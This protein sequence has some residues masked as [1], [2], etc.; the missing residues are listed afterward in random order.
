MDLNYHHLMYFWSVARTG[1]VGRAAEELM[2]SQPTVSAQV[3]A[4]EESLGEPLFARSGRRLVLT[5]AGRTVFDYANE[6][7]ALGR[8]IR[9]ALRHKESGRPARLAV[10][11]SDALP[12]LVARMLIEPALGLGQPVHVVCRDDKAERLL[13]DLAT[14]RLDVVLSDAPAPPTFKARTFSHLLGE[15]GVSFFAAPSLAKRIGRRFPQSLHDAPVILPTDNTMLRRAMDQW[16]AARGVRPRVV[17]EIEDSALLKTFG[18]SGVGAFPAPSVV[19]DVVRAQYGVSV[20][21]RAEDLRERFFAISV[22]RKLR[23]PA[24]IAMTESARR[25]LFDNE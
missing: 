8:Q 14:F 7:F 4:L 12:K 13:V 15:C 10:G 11:V 23:H 18:Q 22:E 24:V 5:D 19:E 6:I 1:G 16:L 25:H 3:K 2:V 20:V 21:G 9:D 17:A